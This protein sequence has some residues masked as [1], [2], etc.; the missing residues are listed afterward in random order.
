MIVDQISIFIENKLGA[1]AE[2]TGVMGDA[3][4]DLRALSLADTTE[5]GVLRLI[6]DDPKRAYSLLREGGFVVSMTQ[7]LTVPI[8]DVPGGLATAL[9]VLTDENVSVEYAYAFISRRKGKAY[10][11]L[12]VE[13]NE[14]AQGILVK[15]GIEMLAK[16][17]ILDEF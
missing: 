15:H 6:V 12:R 7:A 4:I 9:K 13:D 3:G 1:L 2:V 8:D 16:G 11:V 10:V 17:N 5:F 14:Y